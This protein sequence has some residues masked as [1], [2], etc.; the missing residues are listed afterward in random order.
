MILRAPARR[1]LM[2]RI[3]TNNWDAVIVTHSGFERL[4]MSARAEGVFRNATRRLE[5]CI[6]EQKEGSAV[7]G[8]PDRERTWSGRKSGSNSRFKS[9]AAE[10]RK[11]DTLTFEE[12]GV[13]RLFVDEA[14]AFKNLFYVDQNDA[15]GR[16]AADR[17]GAGLRH[18][19]QSA[20]RAA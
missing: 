11:D 8:Q 9:L 18:V 19:P 16:A 14:Q 10:H 1:E 3:A 15:G 7:V 12:L 5:E 17:F 20:A 13:D 2:S 6:R 4:P